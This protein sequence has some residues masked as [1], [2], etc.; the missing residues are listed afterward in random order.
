MLVF[1]VKRY[2]HIFPFMFNLFFIESAVT[3][4]QIHKLKER[5]LE[6]VIFNDV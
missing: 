5:M 2:D 6:G 1:F 3:S 4:N